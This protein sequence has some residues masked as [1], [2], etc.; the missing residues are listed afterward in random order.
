MKGSLFRA[1]FRQGPVNLVAWA[2]LELKKNETMF[3]ALDFLD[4]W[5][6]KCTW[7]SKQ[8]SP[9]TLISTLNVS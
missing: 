1:H 4:K 9:V 8:T 3:L 2:H 6:G 7:S 5:L